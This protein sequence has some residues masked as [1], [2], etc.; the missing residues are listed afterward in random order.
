MKILIIQLARL[1]DIY[2][3][4]PLI[5]GL[6][7]NH[8]DADIDIMVRPRF[9]KACSGLSEITNKLELPMSQ[10]FEPL[11]EEPANTEDSLGILDS[12]VDT[13]RAAQY[14]WIINVSYSPV[15]SFITHAL[16]GPNT[17]VTGYT[18]FNDGFL[19]IPDDGSAYFFAQAGIGR[20]NR[21]HVSDIFCLQGD[22]QM[23]PELWKTNVKQISQ[24]EN[25]QLNCAYIVI[26]IGASQTQ[27]SFP[28]FKWRATINH[29]Q[30]NNPIAVVLIG[31]G[32]EA[33]ASEFISSGT[34]EEKVINLVGKTQL[35]DL[36]P[37]IEKAKLLLG[38]DSAPI[39]IASLTNTPTLNISFATVNFWETGPLADT[40][41]VLYGQDDSDLPS[42]IVARNALQILAGLPPESE[43][44][45]RVAEI[46]SYVV[47]QNFASNYSWNL[48]RALYMDGPF[49][50]VD[51]KEL[52]IAFNQL[53]E[54]NEI[55][56]Q[57][58][59]A[60]E[61][62]GDIQRYRSIYER[63]EEIMG[64]IAKLV[65]ELSPL[66]NWYTTEKVR[67][68]P[69]GPNEVFKKTKHIHNLLQDV[70]TMEG[71]N[72]SFINTTE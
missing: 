33:V 57:Q 61:K 8:P 3:T 7:E 34:S 22:V 14:D 23:K 56:L 32:D 60:M 66:L 53:R 52:Q 63:G 15:S 59:R 72:E 10:I 44:I 18:R 9:A 46:P 70:L 19:S 47:P 26:H 12:F 17:R 16:S 24:Y 48:I 42:E 11:F 49:P 41:R 30:S 37:I 1:G 6:R 64:T 54:T 2:L 50:E 35:T 65:P 36:F 55:M 21:I 28:A 58:L 4:W 5:R 39:H 31:S 43:S 40:S 45:Y 68:G 67:I 51:R 38:C 71:L 29:I 69:D 27:K 13:L 20:Y 25:P 62:S